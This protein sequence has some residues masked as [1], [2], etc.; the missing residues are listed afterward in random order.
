LLL[1]D[2]PGRHRASADRSELGYRHLALAIGCRLER[3][4]R[5][6]KNA[7]SGLGAGGEFD[8]K[9]RLR[10]YCSWVGRG[11]VMRDRRDLP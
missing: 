5:M 10:G 7:R 8:S 6:G 9:E 11:L 4:V 3:H 2:M 1:S